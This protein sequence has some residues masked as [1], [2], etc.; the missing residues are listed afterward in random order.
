MMY[1]WFCCM[2]MSHLA[3]LLAMRPLVYAQGTNSPSTPSVP[4][5][6]LPTAASLDFHV[7]DGSV[8]AVA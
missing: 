8:G 4:E 7:V 5:R 3:G 2:A 6:A 1:A